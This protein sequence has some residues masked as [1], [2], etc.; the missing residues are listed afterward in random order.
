MGS[1]HPRF[2]ESLPGARVSFMV[3]DKPDDFVER[4]E[5]FR[6]RFK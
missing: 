1:L 2:A 6:L 4:P 3:E 5:E